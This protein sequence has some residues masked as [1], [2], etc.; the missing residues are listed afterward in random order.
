MESNKY[1]HRKDESLFSLII[2]YVWKS[3]KYSILLTLV[4]GTFVNKYTPEIQEDVA[5]GDF[6]VMDGVMLGNDS[7]EKIESSYLRDAVVEIKDRMQGAQVDGLAMSNLE[8]ACRQ[9]CITV[10]NPPYYY[11][12]P[13]SMAYAQSDTT[14]SCSVPAGC[15]VEMLAGLSHIKILKDGNWLD[16]ET[17]PLYMTLYR[18]F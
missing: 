18:G 5:S 7:P 3:I 17:F 10:K 14:Q 6:I 15:S 13:G 4:F 9:E 2:S 12:Y 11:S 1:P 16:S 8:N